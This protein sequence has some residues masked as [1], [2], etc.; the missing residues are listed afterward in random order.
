MYA[1]MY[2]N[3]FTY[4]VNNKDPA[5]VDDMNDQEN[6]NVDDDCLVLLLDIGH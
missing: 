5:K 3:T 1:Q 4:Q 2:H 6:E